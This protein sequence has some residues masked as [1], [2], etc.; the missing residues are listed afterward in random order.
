MTAKPSYEELEKLVTSLTLEVAT[1]RNLQRFLHQAEE[2]A[3]ALL[4]ATTDSAI[5]I[6]AKGK[7]LAINEIAA[8]RLSK[9]NVDMVH[10]N[11]LDIL[12]PTLAQQRKSRIDQVL[13]T[14]DPLQFE[15]DYA[16]TTFLN[17]LY[18]VFDRQGKI[19][20]L[21]YFSRDIT[22]KRQFEQEL[23]ES[24]LKFRSISAS[25]QDAFIMMDAQGQISYWNPAAERVFGYRSKEALGRDLHKL[26]APERENNIFKKK[27]SAFKRTGMGGGIGK[28]LEF[29]ALRRDQ[30][31]FPIEL[32]LS[33]LK[34]QGE[35]H[36]FGIVRDISNRK[37]AEKQLRESEKRYKELS[38]TDGLTRLYN[39]RHFYTSLQLEIERSHRYHRSLALLMIDIDDFKKFNDTYGH[40]A[41][42]KVLAKTGAVIRSVLR[43]TDTGYRYGGE[44]FAVILPETVG[45]GAVQVAERIRK[46]LAAMPISLKAKT[47]R[48]ITASM[49]VSELLAKDKLS[50]FIKRA[51]E[52]LYAAKTEGKNRVIF[53]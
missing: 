32:S 43:E 17:S 8:K 3:R 50:E 6:D 25:A 23:R 52:N 49:G 26:L 31:E 47:N 1:C 16:G 19:Q 4:N 13:D 22:A 41:G 42:D 14:G 24:E 46:D 53:I 12:P 2:T 48:N 38:I 34:L 35:W 28:T 44:E 29:V 5:L 9:H 20:N 7:I 21:A 27:F 37:W 18:P 36:S 39:S 10:K 40:L 30:T 33:A 51:D 45:P 15:D 11:L